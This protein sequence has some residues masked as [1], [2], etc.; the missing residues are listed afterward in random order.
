MPIYRRRDGA[1]TADNESMFEACHE[2]LAEGAHLLIFPEGEVH[3][4]PAMLPL[5][6]GAAR[7]ALGAAADAGARGITIVPVGMVYDDKGRFRSQAAIHVGKPIEVDDWV[8]RYRADEHDDGPRAH[9]RRSPS[10]CATSR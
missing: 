8:E 5:K 10:A 1:D 3:R 2:V 7:I 9:R 4:E 6:T